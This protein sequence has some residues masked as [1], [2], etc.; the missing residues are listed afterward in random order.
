MRIGVL[1]NPSAGRGQRAQAVISRLEARWQGHELLTVAGPAAPCFG[2][3]ELL[4]EPEGGYVEKF[5]G[6]VRALL[7]AGAEMIVTLGGDGTAAYAAEALGDSRKT[8]PLLG[9]GLGTANVGPIVTLSGDDPIPPV[10][11][12]RFVPGDAVAV[13]DR[14]RRIAAG[15]ND[16]VLGNTY[17]ATVDGETV[18]A[19]GQA[20]LAEG[21]V[22]RGTPL[23]NVFGPHARVTKNGRHLPVSLPAV[24]QAIAAPLVQDRL[25]GRAV[26]GIY[27]YAPDSPI[28]GAFTLSARP[29]VSYEPDDRGY[30]AF[31]PE[32]RLLFSAADE[33][34]ITGLDSSVLAVCDGNP[35]P[36]TDG[37]VTLHYVPQDV[38]IAKRR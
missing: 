5:F 26:H 12:L 6:S 17:L 15:Y 35:W 33:I 38:L 4:P 11:D 32:E 37:A 2:R 27:C 21:R 10:E 29:L 30:D 22:V 18:T 14:G 9:I 31:A 19:D 16:V 8:V 23:I 25:Y 28:Q 24:G 13:C 1:V 20:L 36:L 34:A 7:I 3:A